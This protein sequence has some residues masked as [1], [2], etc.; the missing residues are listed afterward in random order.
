[1]KPLKCSF[2]KNTFR[3]SMTKFIEDGWNR[4]KMDKPIAI[5]MIACKEHESQ[6]ESYGEKIMAL[7]GQFAEIKPYKSVTINARWG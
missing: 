7:V 6:F 5:E 2:C 1:M 4:I 3:G